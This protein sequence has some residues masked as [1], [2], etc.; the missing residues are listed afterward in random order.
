MRGFFVSMQKSDFKHL[1][2]GVYLA[3]PMTGT[4]KAITTG[5]D[6][7]D[8]FAHALTGDA[9]VSTIAASVA[10]VYSALE[11]RSGM[12]GEIAYAWEL[13]GKPIDDSQLPFTFDTMQYIKRADKAI[14]L[15]GN[16]YL[17]KVRS[18]RGA[19]TWAWVDGGRRRR[20]IY[21]LQW[22]DPRAVTPDPMSATE[23]TRFKYGKYFYDTSVGTYTTRKS[24][25]ADDIIR[26]FRAGL[27]SLDPDSAAADAYNLAAQIIWGMDR[28]TDGLYDTNGLPPIIVKVGQGALKPARDDMQKKFKRFF[29]RKSNGTG[30]KVITITDDVEIVTLALTPKDLAQKSLSDRQIK[31]IYSVNLIP[32]SFLAD[33]GDNAKAVEDSKRFLTTMAARFQMLADALNSDTDIKKLGLKLIVNPQDHYSMKKDMGIVSESV[34]KNVG[35]GM[36]LDAALF[37][38]GFT[39]KDFFPDDMQ[40]IATP[41][42]QETA[43]SAP[44][45]IEVAEEEP[46]GDGL[47]LKK[48]APKTMKMEIK[49]IIEVDDSDAINEFR[50]LEV[51]RGN[52]PDVFLPYLDSLIGHIRYVRIAGR[53]IGVPED[54]LRIHDQSKFSV[55]EFMPYANKFFGGDDSE[56]DAA[57][58]HHKNNNKHHWNHWVLPDEDGGL[59]TVKMPDHYALEMVADWMGASKQYTGSWDMTEWL[60]EKAQFIKLHPPTREYVTMILNGLGYTDFV[61]QEFTEYPPGILKADELAQLKSFVRKGT[62]KKRPFIASYLPLSEIKAE[63]TA[64]N[65]ADLAQLESE[66]QELVVK[67]A[68]GDIDEDT[69]K[70]EY[71]ALFLL[72]LAASAASGAAGDMTAA[73]VA[74]LAVM[75]SEARESIGNLSSEIYAGRYSAGGVHPSN[76]SADPFNAASEALTEESALTKI[77][78][79]VGKWGSSITAAFW[80]GN[81][82]SEANGEE[83]EM[84]VVGATEHCPDCLRLDGQVHTAAEWS[85]VIR[86]KS[87]DL[88]CTG[89]ECQCTLKPVPSDTPT[90]GNF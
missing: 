48:M 49:S 18:G 32:M 67:A 52:D 1:K 75:E 13:N 12:L 61:F 88:A 25:S 51:E 63:I 31:A 38:N 78:N 76:K 50:Y 83:K 33:T 77:V 19:G 35:S 53:K 45:I 81:V 71:L 60:K 89:K 17:G 2:A 82:F 66:L 42:V 65:E 68:N 59:S 43:V 22:L 54:Q 5:N 64:Q 74:E 4:T 15:A 24:I 21:E 11:I 10:W 27:N 8:F 58:L 34:Q 55:Y 80:L 87:P 46:V 20:K 37:F 70:E 6:W 86:P 30:H 3:D 47:K 9:S 26:T 72:A 7:G 90:R 69:F 16:A 29:Q 73:G 56:F 44:E 57:W 28:T 62:H 41:D 79:R 39:M 85:R 23:K 14:Q 36:T 84:W 40:V